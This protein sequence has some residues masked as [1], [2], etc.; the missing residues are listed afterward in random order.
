MAWRDVAGHA[1]V[2]GKVLADKR[3][4]GFAPGKHRV[5]QNG[6][7]EG[8]VIPDS[9][10]YRVLH[11]AYQASSG[12]FAAV[13]YGNNLGQHGIVVTAHLIAFGQAVIDAHAVAAGRLP[14]QYRAGLWHVVLGRVFRVQA[15][16]HGMAGEGDLLLAQW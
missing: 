4:G 8:P 5:T 2:V 1:G 3:R 6:G 15:D 16:F 11:G 9:H 12:V 7:Q 10:Q 14:A 13:A